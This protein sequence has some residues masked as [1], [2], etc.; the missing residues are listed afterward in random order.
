V[1]L[2]GLILIV[3][4]AMLVVGHR[5]P[6]TAVGSQAASGVLLLLIGTGAVVWMPGNWTS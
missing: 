1:I 6:A 5:K 4:A 3:V 2:L